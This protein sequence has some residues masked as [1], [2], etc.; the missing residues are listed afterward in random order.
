VRS[1]RRRG[2]QRL[3]GGSQQL[4]ET[5]NG[6]T[7]LAGRETSRHEEQDLSRTGHTLKHGR[8]Q[9]FWGNP[10]NHPAARQVPGPH[11]YRDRPEPSLINRTDVLSATAIQTIQRQQD[12]IHL[13]IRQALPISPR[14]ETV[15][16]G[17][18]VAQ[19]IESG[20][21]ALSRSAIGFDNQEGRHKFSA[22]IFGGAQPHSEG[23][24]AQL[25]SPPSRRVLTESVTDP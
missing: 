9:D 20:G 3:S 10:L 13:C 11:D 5:L 4:Q 21:Y 14:F 2:S 18:A 24:I 23:R 17:Q 15:E 16:P 1:P 7:A 12:E 22:R 6:E 19:A 8:Q 25:R